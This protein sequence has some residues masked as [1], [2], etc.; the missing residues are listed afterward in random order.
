MFF[1]GDF[2]VFTVYNFRIIDVMRET[3]VG[4]VKNYIEYFC[5]FLFAR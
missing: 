3:D 2:A 1:V 4:A 5:F